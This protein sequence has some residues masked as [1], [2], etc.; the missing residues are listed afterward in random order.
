M[1]IASTIKDLRK[2]HH[3]SQE[4]LADRIGVSRQAITKWETGLGMP[5]IQNICYLA[6]LFGITVDSLLAQSLITG[7][8]NEK[9]LLR[10]YDGYET[11]DCFDFGQFIR[12]I[13]YQDE[14][15][16][17]SVSNFQNKS[18]IRLVVNE[19]YAINLRMKLEGYMLYI[20]GV[21]I[22]PLKTS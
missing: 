3:L 14:Y 6:K 2:T 21:E 1:N 16:D 5:D 11:S 8:E 9:K 19:D 13:K 10:D 15:K 7:I 20:K 18:K 22:E 12:F 17:L 4:Q